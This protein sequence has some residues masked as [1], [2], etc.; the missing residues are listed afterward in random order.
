MTHILR[1][2]HPLEQPLV[3][4]VLQ[5]NQQLANEPT[6]SHNQH[7]LRSDRIL[8]TIMVVGTQ[9]QLGLRHH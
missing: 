8:A 6:V 3:L 7:I 9:L 1:D 4:P 5:V 2:I